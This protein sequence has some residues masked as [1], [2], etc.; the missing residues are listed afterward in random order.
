MGV[1]SKFI[2]DGGF[3]SRK[4]W[5]GILCLVLLTVV[6]CLGV[7]YSVI[8]GLYAEYVGGVLGVYGVYAG[9]NV[10]SRYTTA[11]KLGSKLSDE[12]PAEE[13]AKGD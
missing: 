4:L 11:A 7:H 9:V 6:V 10:A 5:F 13:A 8:A 12:K 2:A 1:L 3:K